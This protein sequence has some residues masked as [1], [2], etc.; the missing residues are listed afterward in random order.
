MRILAT[1]GGFLP[2]DD[3]AAA[4]APRPD[5]RARHPPG[6]RPR[7]AAV[8]LP[9]HRRRRLAHRHHRLL[10]RLRG[11]RRPRHPPRAVHDAERRRHPRAPALPGRHLGRWRIGREPPGRLA[12][13][14]RRRGAARVLGERGR[15]QR[16]LGR[17][18]LLVRRRPHRQLRRRP[19]PLAAGPR[20]PAL[21]QRRPLRQRGAAPAAAARAGREGRPAHLARHRRRRRPRLR[22]HRAGRGGRGP[23]RR[24]GLRRSSGRPTAPS[25][26]RGSSPGCWAEPGAGLPGYP[27]NP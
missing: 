6:G 17:V 19:A 4:L 20:P 8:L 16:C 25:P 26:R 12:G 22:R 27:G 21:R 11:L 1:S 24:R 23:A 5:H 3:R 7:A 9:R 18:D 13:A 2:S 10:Q 15:P 14:P